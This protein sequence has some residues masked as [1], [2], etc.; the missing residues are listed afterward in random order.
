MKRF[1]VAVFSASAVLAC[2]LLFAGCAEVTEDYCYGDYLAE[3]SVKSNDSDGSF[4]QEQWTSLILQYGCQVGVQGGEISKIEI[5]CGDLIIGYSDGSSKKLNGQQ[6]GVG[7]EWND[8]EVTLAPTCAEKGVKLLSCTACTATKEDEI[9]VDLTKHEYRCV[10]AD[11][12][13]HRVECFVCGDGKAENHEYDEWSEHSRV[14]DGASLAGIIKKRACAGCGYTQLKANANATKGYAFLR[15]DNGVKDETAGY[16]EASAA[17]KATAY[18]IKD[19]QIQTLNAPVF[20]IYTKNYSSITIKEDYV[21]CD[22]TL[23]NTDDK[24][25]LNNVSAG[26]RLRGNSTMKY[27]KKPYRIKFDKKQGLF[28]WEKNKSWVLLALYQ[29]FSNIKDYAA[30]TIADTLS[31]VGAGNSYFTPNAKHVELYLNGE[32][33][34]LYLL[35]DQ[36][37]ENSGRVGVEEDFSPTAT[38]VPF[39]VEMDDYAPNEGVEGK[40]YFKIV[41]SNVTNY[42]NVKYPDPEQRYTQAQYNYIKDFVVAVDKLCHDSGVTRAEFEKL[43]DLPSFIDYFLVQELMGQQEINKKSVYMSRKTG[44]KLVMGPVWDFDWSAGGPM[45]GNGAQHEPNRQLYSSTNWFACMLKVSWFKTAVLQ[46]LDEVKDAVNG[47]LDSLAAYKLQIKALS[48]RNAALWDF[49]TNNTLPSFNE[50]YD[51]VLDFIRQKITLIPIFLQY[52][53]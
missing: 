50:Y 52:I 27:P 19:A 15:W 8:G 1:L 11:D 44:G 40:D 28:G 10:P 39:L 34:G 48:E 36:V 16:N 13:A 26:I 17:Q 41:N 32:Y 42:F 31:G 35:C 43:V 12:T 29:D 23:L 6:S 47:T 53:N 45:S 2:A 21:D 33:Q 14:T 3:Y 18:F 37:Q 7:H 25:C 49:D 46:R 30:F 22:V 38:E 4:T 9:A 20:S 51:T 24:F 5:T